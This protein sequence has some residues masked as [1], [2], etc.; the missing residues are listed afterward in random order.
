VTQDDVAG[1]PQLDA[2]LAA[3]VRGVAGWPHEGVRFT[4]VSAVWEREP[5]LFRRLVDRMAAPYATGPAP[6]LLTIEARAFLF[7][8]AMAHVLG[9]RV[10][11]ARK[12]PTPRLPREFV[13]Q[14]YVSGYEG[15]LVMGAHQD[16]VQPGEDVL[17]VDDVLAMGWSAVGGVRLARKLGASCVGVTVAIELGHL[18]GRANLLE[19]A[20]VPLFAAARTPNTWPEPA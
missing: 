12:G 2:D 10:V 14:E 20:G 6:I 8:G 18:P 11:M 16:A 13:T 19:H 5:S 9:A 1:D 15:G 7:A 3:V 4:D 17:V